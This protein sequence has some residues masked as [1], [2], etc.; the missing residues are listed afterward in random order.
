MSRKRLSLRLFASV[1]AAACVLAVP[2]SAAVAPSG[3]PTSIG[4][5]GAAASVET[6]ATQAA[7][8]TLKKGGNAIDAAVTAAGVLGVTEPFSCGIGGGG[9]MVI[10]TADGRV[11][12]IDGRERASAAMTPTSFW[13]NGAPLP[14]NDARFSG[15]AVGVPGT[16]ATWAN[17]LDKYGTISL[18]DALQAG[19]RVAR[20][21]YAIDQVWVDQA[22]SVRDWFDDVPASAKLFLDPDGT[23]K[24]VGTVFANP[25]LAATYERIAHLGPKGFYR[26]A[27][28]D[29]M[30]NTVR[31]PVISPAANHVWRPGLMT[32][33]DLHR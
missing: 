28:A 26:G 29:A 6:L 13:E 17:A 10:R 16:V 33:R 27:V 4:T 21:G 31:Q 30:V 20:N 3:P 2:A 12:T 22:N 14:F 23:V 5:G 18:A 25:E 24:D 8:D 7:I 1:A 19:I 11:V 15:M 9:F 32:M